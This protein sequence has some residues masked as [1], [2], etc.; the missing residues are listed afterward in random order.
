MNKSDNHAFVNQ[1]LVYTLVMICLSGS[2]G[3]GTVWMRHQI[4]VTANSTRQMESRIAQAERSL[5]ETTIQ[6]AAEESLEVLT[7]RNSVWKLGLLPP[8][9]S[10]VGRLAG[11]PE[12]RLAALRNREAFTDRT[13]AETAPVVFASG[14][15]V[16]R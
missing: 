8:V 10:Q 3:L 12:R 14:S 9:E 4:S 1:L 6:V 7:R 11:S 5:A 2:I 15:R 13:G 16:R